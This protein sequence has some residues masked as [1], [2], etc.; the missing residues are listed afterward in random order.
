MK[1][2]GLLTMPL[3]DN[4]GGIIQIAALYH[5]IESLGFE[6]VL[7]DKK[8]NLSDS[9]VLIKKILSNNPL[10][11]IYDFKGYTKRKKKLTKIDEFI[12]LYFVNRTKEIYNEKTLIEECSDLDTII[13][14]SDQVWRYK[15]VKRDL[16][17]YFLSFVNSK[18]KKLS[19][20]ASF[21]VE[22]WEGD[23]ESKNVVTKLLQDFDAVSIREDEGVNLVKD[24]F[25]LNNAVQ[26]LD[27]TLLP[28]R[29]FYDNLINQE[30]LSK[31]I[32][33]FNY[34]LD[35]NDLK[36]K[37][38]HD[39]A[40]NL[41]L[42]VDMIHLEEDIKISSPKPS[43]S[44]WLFHFKNADFVIT[45]SFHGTVF[46]IIYNKQFVS[47]ANKSRG[48]SRFTSLLKQLG[49]EN[50]LIFEDSISEF[51]PS[52][53]KIIDYDLVKEK[54]KTLRNNSIDFLKKNI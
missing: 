37:F 19:Y 54:I 15:Y 12:R 51:D 31:K 44:E 28:D 30:N 48:V 45:D 16:N 36:T 22:V 5:I 32:E 53:L 23:Q 41:N 3:I 13:V 14:G 50:R 49:L 35:L 21:G 34:V 20:A 2:V 7:I 11:K 38:I 47:I 42:R 4:Y 46:S 33:L 8:Y 43:L 10:Y 29:K 25:S 26:V 27:P 9:K 17:V 1:K 24:R 40:T 6:P 52:K 18:Q 39:F